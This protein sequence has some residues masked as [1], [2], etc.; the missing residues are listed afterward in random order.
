MWRPLGLPT[1]FSHFCLS[2]PK[3]PKFISTSYS[4]CWQPNAE[5]AIFV[6]ST[7]VYRLFFKRRLA[8]HF[9]SPWLR[10]YA[11]DYPRLWR[12]ISPFN[13]TQL[14]WIRW[15]ITARL[16]TLLATMKTRRHNDLSYRNSTGGLV[17]FDLNLPPPCFAERAAITIKA[18]PAVQ[19]ASF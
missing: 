1:L 4:P 2:A 18:F 15:A 5:K 12:S 17:V 16:R 3:R 11:V 9:N 8:E 14:V 7:V 19:W 6:W 10:F 13:T